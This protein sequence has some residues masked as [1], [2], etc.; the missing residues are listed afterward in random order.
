[1]EEEFEMKIETDENG[2][3]KSVLNNDGTKVANG[4]IHSIKIDM[5]P[6]ENTKIEMVATL[7]DSSLSLTVDDVVLYAEL[8]TSFANMSKSQ[9]LMFCSV[10]LDE[11]YILKDE[12][13][14]DS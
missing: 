2:F 6:T 5:Q 10:L 11:G 4:K 9:R 3:V 14:S 7:T 1:M 13:K 12:N 8:A